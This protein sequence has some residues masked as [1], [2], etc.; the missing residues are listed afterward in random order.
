VIS[1]KISSHEVDY[2][3]GWVEVTKPNKRI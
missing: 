1:Y 3:V 2:I